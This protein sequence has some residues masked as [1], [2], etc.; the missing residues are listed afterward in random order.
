MVVLFPIVA[1]LIAYL[2]TKRSIGWGLAAT[3]GFGY[4]N[5]VIRAN[6]LSVYTTFMFDAAVL[7]LYAGALVFQSKTVYEGLKTSVGKWLLGMMMWPIVLCCLPVNDYLVQL[8]AL[9]GSIWFLPIILLA[10]QLT[11]E[12]YSCIGIALSLLNLVTLMVSLYLMQNGVEALYPSNAV[13]EIIYLSRDVGSDNL[14]RIPSTFL[15]SHAYG[16]TMMGSITIICGLILG[17]RGGI[18]H[19][20]LYAVG[21]IAAVS[22]VVICASRQP[23]VVGAVILLSAWFVSGYSKKFSIVFV[24]IAA[25]VGFLIASNERFQRVLTLNDSVFL[26]QRVYSSLNES[27]WEIFW[28]YPLGAGLG[29]SV[30]TSIPYFLVSRAPQPI[31]IENELCRIYVDQGIIGLTI[32]ISFIVW[33]LIR[34]PRKKSHIVHMAYAA[35]MAIWATSFIGTGLLSS[36]PGTAMLMMQMGVVAGA[37]IRRRASGDRSAPVGQSESEGGLLQKPVR[38]LTG[39]RRTFNPIISPPRMFDPEAK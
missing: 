32:W 2:L 7:G 8:V 28:T 4:F 11:D 5:G 23:M 25:L 30:G 1:F 10:S 33:L 39:P 35:T 17:Q 31:G 18:T 26:H 27:L 9:R 29:S 36:V 21:L 3:I 37:R 38:Y 6:F 14:H 22:G 16:G 13:T 19:K 20:I 34:I 12:D 15:S 24:T